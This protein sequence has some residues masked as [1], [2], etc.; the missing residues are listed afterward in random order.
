MGQCS[1]SLREGDIPLIPPVMRA[2][3]LKA[4]RRERSDARFRRRRFRDDP[5]DPA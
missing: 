5:D 1:Q 3:K 2:M 4:E